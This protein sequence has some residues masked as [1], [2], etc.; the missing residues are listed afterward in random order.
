M[1]I[2]AAR[3]QPRDK[4]ATLAAAVVSAGLTLFGLGLVAGTAHADPG[5]LPTRWQCDEHGEHCY[6]TDDDEAPQPWQPHPPP[7]RYH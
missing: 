3:P 5:P 2:A 1:G 4:R 6:H 7:Q